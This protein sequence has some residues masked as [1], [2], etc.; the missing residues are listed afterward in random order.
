MARIGKF[1]RVRAVYVDR[2]R[3]GRIVRRSKILDVKISQK[4][5]VFSD[6]I[7]I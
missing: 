4:N 2:T 7:Y 6:R 5:L 3:M 1:F